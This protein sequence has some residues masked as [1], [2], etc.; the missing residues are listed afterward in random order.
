MPVIRIPQ[1]VFDRLQ[2]IAKPFVDSPASVVERLL[3]F[4]DAR[5]TRAVARRAAP[6][7]AL[8]AASRE[9]DTRK[10]PDLLHT[11]VLSAEF[12]G[13]SADSWNGLTV[14]A[15]RRAMARLKSVDALRKATRANIVEGRRSDSNYHYQADVNVSVQAVNANDAWGSSIHLAQHLGVPIR[16]VF[17]WRRKKGASRPGQQ[18]SLDW[19]P[20]RSSDEA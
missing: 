17:E 13:Q 7:R 10:P 5:Q 2:G 16:V 12:D 18:G 19:R 1:P 8:K 11:K 4:Y 6:R 20:S 3:D 15:H 9:F 14:L